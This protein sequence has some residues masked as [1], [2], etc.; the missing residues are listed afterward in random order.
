[1]N[2]CTLISDRDGERAVRI[3]SWGHDYQIKFM[4]KM[5]WVR[6]VICFLHYAAWCFESKNNQILRNDLMMVS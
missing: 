4:S 3:C 1:M 2:K 6:V 5:I